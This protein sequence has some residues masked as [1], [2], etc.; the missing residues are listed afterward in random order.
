MND[1]SLCVSKVT[2][3]VRRIERRKKRTER[4]KWNL[5]AVKSYLQTSH[6]VFQRQMVLQRRYNV[7]KILHTFYALNM[8]RIFGYIPYSENPQTKH[9]QIIQSFSF[10][11]SPN[12][13]VLRS[14]IFV[15]SVSSLLCGFV[16]TDVFLYSAF[17][18]L[19]FRA[20]VGA[21][22]FFRRFAFCAPEV[23]C[24]ASVRLC[25]NIF[26]GWATWTTC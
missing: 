11:S 15:H 10:K 9:M 12:L 14:R 7:K 17:L 25:K 5:Q 20:G 26:G 13:F 19:P 3:R 23:R 1:T 16:K 22:I 24:T 8:S 4:N 2:E 21:F 6:I 18:R